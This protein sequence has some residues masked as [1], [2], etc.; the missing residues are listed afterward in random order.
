MDLASSIAGWEMWGGFL[1]FV[2]GLL[3]LDLGIFHRQAHEV[4][5]KEAG[6]WSVVWVALATAFGVG[7]FHFFGAQKALE[8]ATGYVIEKAL[9][10]DNIFVFV[11]IFGYFSIPKKHQHRVLFWGILGALLMRGGFIVLGGALIEKFHWVM[12]VFGAILLAT[13]A[14]LFL[15]KNEHY[16]P[17]KNPVLRIFKR[18]VPTTTVLAE[19]RFFVRNQGRIFATPLFVALLAVEVTD[20][21]FAVDSIPAIFAITQDPFIVFTSNIFAILGLRSLYFLLA[22]IVDRFVF[23]KTGLALVLVFIGAKMLFASFF[24]IPTAASLAVIAFLIGG[25]VVLS[26]FK[27]RPTHSIDF[28]S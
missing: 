5:L 7:V 27:T 16:D 20:L 23:L 9:S 8:F 24:K 14:K 17:G 18:F 26:L 11:V 6:V 21:I 13:G 4:S 2:F 1:I 10:V 28:S 3:A 12:Y 22:G 25:S 19:D 15:Q